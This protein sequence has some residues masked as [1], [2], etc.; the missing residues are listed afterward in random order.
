MQLTQ[1]QFQRIAHCF[2][3]PRGG[4]TI[5]NLMVINALLYLI[6]NSC[7]WRRLPE[8]YGNWHTIYTR[9]SRWAKSGVLEAIFREMQSQCMVEIKIESISLDSTSVK[10][11]P[12]GTGA[13]KKTGRRPSGN[14]GEDGTPNFIWQP[15]MRSCL[16]SSASPPDRTVT[17]RVEGS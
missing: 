15:V 8:R 9:V 13:Q 17:A 6:E 14:R 4:V 2:P 7:K 3:T 5:D 10:V 1:E 12:D 11:H 16:S